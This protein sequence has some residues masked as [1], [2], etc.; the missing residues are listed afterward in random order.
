MAAYTIAKKLS[1]CRGCGDSIVKGD[2]RITA[3]VEGSLAIAPV[4][5][6]RLVVMWASR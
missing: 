5:Q 2:L 1:S 6:V 3:E 4:I